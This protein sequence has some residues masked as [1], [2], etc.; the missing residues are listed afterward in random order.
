[1]T[2]IRVA[3]STLHEA[4]AAIGRATDVTRALNEAAQQLRRLVRCRAIA[5]ELPDEKTERNALAYSS[6]FESDRDADAALT[7]SDRSE[8]ASHTEGDYAVVSSPLVGEDGWSGLLLV[9]VDGD[10]GDASTA[11]DVVS[12]IAIHLTAAVD[13]FRRMSGAER[14]LRLEAGGSMATAIAHSLR[15]A[16]YGI[17]SAAQ[18]LRFR[19]S[20]D[21]VLERNI[22]RLLR[23]ADR[24]SRLVDSL[25]DFGKP[26][27]LDLEPSDPERAWDD[28]IEGHRGLL[29]AKSLQ[30]KRNRAGGITVEIDFRRISQ[31]LALL[32][33]A[34]AERVPDASDIQLSGEWVINR[35]RSSLTIPVGIADDEVAR[36]FDPLSSATGGQAGVG[37]ALCRRI[38]EGHGGRL[39]AESDGHGSTT[40]SVYLQGEL[41]SAP[42]SNSA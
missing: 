10:S 17:S 3:P 22:G 28:V 1:M 14:R 6:G 27:E 8:P 21:P 5:V 30:V 19:A 23:E 39:I 24:V 26:L 40:F 38:V 34:A 7:G 42:G 4:G 37:L 13:R 11:L 9:R 12:T 29:E 15:H 31:A 20:E 16:L 36:L 41:A 18:L 35:W 25:L 2:S 32:L 33:E